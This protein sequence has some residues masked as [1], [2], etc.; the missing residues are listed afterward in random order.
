MSLWFIQTADSFRN[1]V[2]GS[3]HEWVF[4]SLIHL[5]CLKHRTALCW[6]AQQFCCGFVGN[7]FV[8]KTEQKQT[9]LCLKYNII[10]TY[11]LL[12]RILHSCYSD[13]NSTL[14]ILLSL[15]VW[16]RLSC[17]INM[18]SWILGHNCIYEV[19]VLHHIC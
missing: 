1:S 13:I 18:R 4:E 11:Y 7:I 15:L 8:G 17:D 5:I 12:N 16:Y 9:I 10:L 3:L 19:V 14:V 6:D 2:N